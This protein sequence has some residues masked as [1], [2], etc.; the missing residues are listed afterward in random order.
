MTAGPQVTDEELQADVDAYIAAG[1]NRSE[2]ARMRNLPRMTFNDRLKSAEKRLGIVLG[3][4]AD[5]RIE[6]V[7]HDKLELPPPGQ[8]KRYVITS[9]QNNTYLH[10]GWINLKAYADYLNQFGAGCEFI[11][12]TFSYALDA[13]GA[14]AVKR[15]SWKPMDSLWYANEIQEY[16]RDQRLE[17]APGLIWCGEM[18]ILPTAVNPL[19]GLETYNGRNSNIVPHAKVAMD[20][21][22]SLPDEATKFNFSTGTI[23]QRNYIQ[24]R[25]GIIAEPAHAYGGVIVEI[26][27][28]GNW[29]VRQLHIDGNGHVYDVGPSERGPLAPPVKISDGSV[30]EDPGSVDSLVWADVHASEMDDWVKRL[31]WGPGGMLDVL[32]PKRQFWHDLFSM[33]SRG[34][35]EMKDFHRMYQKMV[36]GQDSV[37]GEVRITAEFA[38]MADR[39]WCQAIVVPSNH[40]RHLDRWL[41]EE[42]PR[43]DPKNAGYHM[44]LQSAKL[45]AMDEGDRNFS[46]LEWA[47]R[48]FDIFPTQVMFLAEDESYVICRDTVEGGIECGMHGDRGPGGSRGSTRGLTRLGRSV[49][50]GHDHTAA[51]RHNVYSVGACSLSFPY[52]KGPSA[53]S[54]THCVVFENGRRQLITM[55]AGKWR[56]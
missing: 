46:I 6:A 3:K 53:H 50:K 24:K 43:K 51:I 21:V 26:N 29:W 10:P 55:W 41:N 35:H 33:R 11:V 7:E 44:M 5:G 19:N 12:G 4:M 37:E 30:S 1:G 20:S 42:D 17:L 15:G 23:T 39:D 54:V 14:K 27:S 48:R 22:P 38:Q 52:M 8:I 36:D 32:R 2:A 31:G 45:R 28:D 56:A 18:N 13:Y 25:A 16:I 9:V 34:H 47:L 49:I 40:D